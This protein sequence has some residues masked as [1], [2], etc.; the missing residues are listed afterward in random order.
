MKPTKQKPKAAH[1]GL[2]LFAAAAGFAAGEAAVEHLP[3][4]G[5]RSKDEENLLF[6]MADFL[7][8][9]L[10]NLPEAV[11]VT[12]VE[13]Q[14]RRNFEQ[15]IYE[16]FAAVDAHHLALREAGIENL[17]PDQLAAAAMDADLRGETVEIEEIL[18]EG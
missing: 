4:T 18:K 8:S 6:F 3:F 12:E 9:F 11:S 7:E 16:H 15:K 10:E 1:S 5:N 14:F 2:G 17:T 13:Q